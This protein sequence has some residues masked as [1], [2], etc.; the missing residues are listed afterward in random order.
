V[1]LVVYGVLAGLWRGKLDPKEDRV[2][3]PSQVS[4]AREQAEGP[5]PVSPDG[6]PERPRL[7]GGRHR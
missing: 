5:S 2:E 1:G 7:V 6:D 4:R 3:G